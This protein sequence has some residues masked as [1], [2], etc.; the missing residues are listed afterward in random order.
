MTRKIFIDCG[1]HTGNNIKL[2]LKSEFYSDEY[3]IYAFECNPNLV[4]KFNKFDDTV[5]FKLIQ[6]AVW[7]EDGKMNFYLGSALS[8]TLLSNKKTGGI[9]ENKFV[10][11][12]SIDLDQWIKNSFS[13]DDY[14][15]LLMDIEGAEYDVINKM[16]IGGSLD[17]INQFYLEFHGTKLKNFNLKIEEDMMDMLIK[18]FKKDIYIFKK[19]QHNGF[20]K[21]NK[22]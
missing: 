13:K 4:K 14:I 18:K 21:L 12:E 3:E 19:H 10:E 20:L 6:K 22:D 15:I 11:V 16:K 9:N 1:A 2:F 7:V 5:N 17:Y 8:S